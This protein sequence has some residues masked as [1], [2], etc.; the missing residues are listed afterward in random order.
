M[1][2]TVV[3]DYTARQMLLF[4]EQKMLDQIKRNEAFLARMPPSIQERFDH[5]PSLH[6]FPRRI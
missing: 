2:K 1:E 3:R 5:Y 4:Q 6:R